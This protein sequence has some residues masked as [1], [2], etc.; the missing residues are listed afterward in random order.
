M[1]RIQGGQ[2]GAP[3]PV[4][5]NLRSLRVRPIL[6]EEEP[7]WNELMARCH[8]LG[9][10]KLSGDQ[11]KY[12]ALLEGT[13]VAL[14]GWGAAAFKC[15]PRDR[16]I[17]WTPE[18]QWQ[19]LRYVVNNQRFLVLVRIPN[20]ASKVLALNLKR[21]SADWQ[22]RFGYPVVLAE[23]FIDPQR[24][25]GTA[26]RA[27]GWWPL[28]LTRGYGRSG[29]RYYRHDHPKTI[30]VRPLHPQARQLLAAPFFP[31]ELLGKE[32][33]VVD[34]ARANLD[35]SN[36][37]LER[38]RG[39]VDPRKRRG[40]RHGQAYVLAVSA[41]AVLCGARSMLAIAEWAKLQPQPLLK[42]LGARYNGRLARYMPPS[43]PTIRRILQRIDAQALESVLTQ[44]LQAE[45]KSDAVA[46]DGKTARGAKDAEGKRMHLVA[47]LFHGQGVVASQRRVENKSNEIPAFRPLLENMDLAGRVVTGDALHA[48]RDHARFV[49]EDKRADYLFTVKANQPHLFEA[50][51]DL[52]EDAFSPSAG[53]AGEGPRPHR[54][55]HHPDLHR[56]E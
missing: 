18:Q 33:A 47:A 27:A 46:V 9:F 13:W 51:R 5:V 55:P 29:G 17:G 20:L 49:V 25:R 32:A 28:G 7:A 39:L 35:G 41:C 22:A 23:T 36:G 26:Y 19:R 14:L 54:D 37:L 56:A 6:P 45:A 53:R 12:V 31:P 8:Y 21:L 1:E 16:W 52:D 40:I 15:R 34:L 38:L 24:F 44:W 50:L 48:Q 4:L 30:W 43:E 11:L 10:R 3:Q 2:E 42:R